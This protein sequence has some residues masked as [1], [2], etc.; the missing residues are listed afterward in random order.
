M[1]GSLGV[2]LKFVERLALAAAL[3]LVAPA[4]ARATGPESASAPPA[5]SRKRLDLGLYGSPYR[6]PSRGQ[7]SQLRFEAWVD[8]VGEPKPDPN[9]AM[10][11]WWKRFDIGDPAIYGQGYNLRPDA[12]PNSINILPLLQKAYEKLKKR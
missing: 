8:V 7:P 10:E 1:A 2:R 6:P 11:L 3:L 5:A 12:Q 4:S 9:Q